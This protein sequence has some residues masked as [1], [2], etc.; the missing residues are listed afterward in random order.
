LKD[1]YDFYER[2]DPKMEMFKVSVNLS[3]MSDTEVEAMRTK[4]DMTYRRLKEETIGR[5]VVTVE[6][7]RRR[8]ARIDREFR[9]RIIGRLPDEGV[10]RILLRL[11]EW[12]Y[13]K[14]QILLDQRRLQLLGICTTQR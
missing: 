11:Y 2:F 12:L 5:K 7:S 3:N 10:V 1:H 13:D 9:K 8:L 14:A 4:L 6:I